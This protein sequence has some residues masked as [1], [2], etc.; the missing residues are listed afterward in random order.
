MEDALRCLRDGAVGGKRPPLVLL[1]DDADVLGGPYV[2][3][4]A[5]IHAFCEHQWYF[6]RR[7]C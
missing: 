2:R 1:Q 6:A 3:D 5:R 7:N 4:K